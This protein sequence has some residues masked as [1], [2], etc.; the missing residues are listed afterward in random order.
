MLVYLPACLEEIN[1]ILNWTI[2]GDFNEGTIY[3][4][5]NGMGHTPGLVTA[6]RAYNPSP[7]RS[8]IRKSLL[9]SEM[10]GL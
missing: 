7:P 5:P 8:K 4:S 9:E 3:N 6:Q 10:K 2:G 1:V